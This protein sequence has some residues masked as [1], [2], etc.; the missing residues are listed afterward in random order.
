M[1]ED[2]RCTKHKRAEQR[3]HDQ[4]RGSASQRGYGRTWQKMSKGFLRAHPLCQCP[5]CDEGR[6]R[7]VAADVV[8]HKV[9]HHGDRALFWARDNWQALCAPHHNRDKQSQ[10][11]TGLL[12]GCDADGLPLDEAHPWR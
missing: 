7:V 8:D 5:Q 4:Q 9:P 12:P 11:R 10:E 1:T 6:V 3:Q 2:G